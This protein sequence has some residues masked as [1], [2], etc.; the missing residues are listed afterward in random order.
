MSAPGSTNEGKACDAV[1]RELERR[2]GASRHGLIFPSEPAFP[3]DMQVEVIGQVGAQK[4]ALEHT[5][6]EPF[7]GYRALAH[8][9]GPLRTWL[10]DCFRGALDPAVSLDLLI[11]INALANRRPRELARMRQS[12][13]SWVITSAPNLT[14]DPED[15]APALVREASAEIPFR[16]SLRRRSFLHASPRFAVYSVVPRDSEQLRR[17][18]LREGYWRKSEKLQSVKKAHGVRT[19]LVLEEDDLAG[20]NQYL[21]AAAVRHIERGRVSDRPDEVYLVSTA[22]KP[23]Y[24]Y[25]IRIGRR[26]VYNKGEPDGRFRELDPALLD[27]ITSKGRKL[28]GNLKVR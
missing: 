20:T 18:R 16:V 28:L 10:I 8:Q 12:I 4:L 2:L 3:R 26:W 22:W 15:R 1:L 21:V 7:P 11:P 13:A 14:H 23:W 17:K 9:V 19:V 5:Y 27:D 25:P 6:T 24:L